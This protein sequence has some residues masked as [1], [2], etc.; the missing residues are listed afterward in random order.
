[1][2]GIPRTGALKF[3]LLSLTAQLFLASALSA[4]LKVSIIDVGQGDA[5][6]IELPS[7]RNALID[8]G[9]QAVVL[10]DFLNRKGITALDNV[11]LTHP[12]ADHYSGLIG[13]PGAVKIKKFYDTRMDNLNASADNQLRKDIA[14]DRG[15]G[16]FYP[17]AGEML[18]WDPQVSVQVLHSCS[19]KVESNLG[20]DINNCSIV[21]QLRYNGSTLL[22]MGDAQTEAEDE[23][24]NRFGAGVRS[25]IMKVAH[26]G[27][28]N[29]SSPGFLAMVRPEYAY[30]SVG[31][32]NAFGH[33]AI[34]TLG[35][36]RA[37]SAAILMTTDGTQSFTIPASRGV[38]YPDPGLNA[39]SMAVPSE[40]TGMALT[41]AASG[42]AGTES[43]ALRQLAA[44]ASAAK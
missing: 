4:Q 34:D 14:S 27:A 33:P 42:E 1:M 21:L 16:V 5:I 35:N 13:L 40:F 22:L 9:P 23:I 10:T 20:S 44:E 24:V 31:L 26:H 2:K 28:A 17:K 30:I 39:V 12:H 15:C 3:L 25:N 11:V 43:Q 8:G 19:S 41:G 37:V 6:Y 18:D 32:D 7:G 36:L 38:P 29:A